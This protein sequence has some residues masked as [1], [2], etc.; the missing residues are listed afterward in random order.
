MIKIFCCN[1]LCQYNQNDG[2]YSLCKYTQWN[3]LTELSSFIPKGAKTFHVNR[4]IRENFTPE[5]FD[6]EKS[7][8]IAQS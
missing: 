6:G 1:H 2:V 3:N 4:C 7:P 5:G 8:S